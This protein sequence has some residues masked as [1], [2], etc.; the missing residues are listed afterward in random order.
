ML[1]EEYNDLRRTSFVQMDYT[2]LYHKVIL[3]DKQTLH[4]SAMANKHLNLKKIQK[5]VVEMQ[6]M[7]VQEKIILKCTQEEHKVKE[8]KYCNSII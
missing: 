8:W 3:K 1:F 2:I 7:M 5:L 6:G 4:T